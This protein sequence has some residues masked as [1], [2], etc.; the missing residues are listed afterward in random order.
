MISHKEWSMTISR[1]FSKLKRQEITSPFNSDQSS[2]KFAVE[3]GD[4]I[5]YPPNMGV[6]L[7]CGTPKSSILIGFS[8]INH[9]FWGT[10]IFGNTQSLYVPRPVFPWFMSA[11]NSVNS[12]DEAKLKANLEKKIEMMEKFNE[13]PSTPRA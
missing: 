13:F 7:N 1:R 12:K 10:P 9:P 8:I 5:Y 2:G 6:S 3:S 11:I 4:C